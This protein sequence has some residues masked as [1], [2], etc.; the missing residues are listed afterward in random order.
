MMIVHDFIGKM[1]MQGAG[2]SIT[3]LSLMYQYIAFQI[4]AVPYGV[5]NINSYSDTKIQNLRQGQELITFI[6][7]AD[8]MMFQAPKGIDFRSVQNNLGIAVKDTIDKLDVLE[9]FRNNDLMNIINKQYD[10]VCLEASNKLKINSVVLL[11]NIANE[12]KREPLRLARIAEIK[13]SR[14]G[15]QRVVVVTYQNVSLNKKGEWVGN[16][17]TVERCV[18]D[19]ILVDNALNESM[20]NPKLKT[21]NNEDS[22]DNQENIEK[23]RRTK[24]C[25]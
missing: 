6:R 25:S 21:Q 10:N 9:E 24:G 8:W 17:V 2:M 4:N 1:K 20:L 7:P 15:T 23:K 3:D 19:V 22:S 16:P 18:S 12:A 13:E 14:D 5:R 11:K